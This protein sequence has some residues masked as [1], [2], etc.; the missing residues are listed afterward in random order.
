VRS[1]AGVKIVW[2]SLASNTSDNDNVALS[3][4][5]SG[6]VLLLARVV[7]SV[8]LQRICNRGI[9]PRLRI[10]AGTGGV[11]LCCCHCVDGK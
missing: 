11:G 10:V 6:R 8:V 1:Q 9:E 3:I 7:D 2:L 5:L 4:L